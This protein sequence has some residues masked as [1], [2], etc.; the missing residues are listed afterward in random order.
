M[1]AVKSK[2]S[3]FETKL[4][5]FDVLVYLV[6]DADCLGGNIFSTTRFLFRVVCSAVTRDDIES[7]SCSIQIDCDHDSATDSQLAA[8]TYSALLQVGIL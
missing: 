3:A 8:A 4:S 6:F 1:L 7:V 2:F 5:I